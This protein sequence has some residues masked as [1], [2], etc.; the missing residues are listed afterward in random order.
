MLL[1]ITDIFTKF[2]IIQPLKEAKAKQLAFFTENMVFLLFG[3]PEVVL[4]D[5]GAQFVSKELKSLLEKY[6]VTQWLTP[7]YFPQVNNVE[8]TNRVFTSA[9]RTLIKKKQDQWDA[10]IY[11][12]ENAINNATHASSGFSPYFI[13]FGRNQISS[14]EE[15]QNLRELQEGKSQSE[16]EHSE[17]MKKKFEKILNQP[18]KNILGTTNYDQEKYSN[19]PKRKKF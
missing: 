9:I 8:R 6:G 14:G 1:V 5:N 10:N 13:N 18:T 12:I 3:V 11:Q 19:I 17:K 16:L 4:S 2:V 15:Y 7:V